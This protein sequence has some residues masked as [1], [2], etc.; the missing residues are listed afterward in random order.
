MSY[1]ADAEVQALN[2]YSYNCAMTTNIDYI[3]P[4][5][6]IITYDPDTNSITIDPQ[7]N[8]AT[9]GTTTLIVIVRDSDDFIIDYYTFEV[10][11]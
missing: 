2:T 3:G 5:Q 6:S 7:N 10:I 11:I 8:A 1:I 4:A 9:E